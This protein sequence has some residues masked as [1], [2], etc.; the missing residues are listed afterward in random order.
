MQ[1]RDAP[2]DGPRRARF[3]GVPGANTYRWRSGATTPG[4]ASVRDGVVNLYA[5]FEAG[6]ARA[7]ETAAQCLEWFVAALED[8]RAQI[9]LR[10]QRVRLALPAGVGCDLAGGVWPRYADALRAWRD[11]HADV[12]LL[13]YVN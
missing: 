1:L 9:L 4:R 7:P 6:P 10:R 8:A 12:D 2:R 11:A 3:R 5:Q 13:F